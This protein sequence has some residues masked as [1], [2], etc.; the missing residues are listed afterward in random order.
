MGFCE[1]LL[2]LSLKPSINGR[3]VW[4]EDGGNRSTFSG[5]RSIP[6]F[7]VDD[8]G[9]RTGV[10]IQLPGNCRYGHSLPKVQ[11]ANDLLVTHF[12]HPPVSSLTDCAYEGNF[13]QDALVFLHCCKHLHFFSA[14]FGILRLQMYVLLFCTI[15]HL[16]N[17]TIPI[18][19][20][21]KSPRLKPPR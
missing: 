14:T 20:H 16:K 3:L 11:I 10:K 17:W 7:Q 5:N 9:N 13:S 12:Q 15:Q 8:F 4:I 1:H 6:V 21:C 2:T 18:C 19:D